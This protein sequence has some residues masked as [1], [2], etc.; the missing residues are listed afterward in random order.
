MI[1]LPFLKFSFN[2]ILYIYYSMLRYE[3]KN[4]CSFLP[5]VF[6]YSPNMFTVLFL[7]MFVLFL[8]LLCPSLSF[9]VSECFVVVVVVMT[10]RKNGS[11]C[12][13][14]CLAIQLSF[15]AEAVVVF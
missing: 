1:P 14:Q 10:H 4:V 7:C 11:L 9:V 15:V 2:F 5:S 8:N 3:K 13:D 12:H 6:F